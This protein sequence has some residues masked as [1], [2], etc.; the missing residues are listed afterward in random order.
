MTSPKWKNFEE[1]VVAIQRA[2]SPSDALITPNDRLPELATGRLREVDASIRYQVGGI[3][4]LITVECRDRATLEGSLWTEQLA[5]KQHDQGVNLTVAVSSS[6]FYG[7][8]IEKAQRHG[9][10]L[11][12]IDEV[13]LADIRS[14]CLLTGVNVVQVS[15]ALEGVKISSGSSCLVADD[16]SM[17]PVVPG[18]RSID[19]PRFYLV[20]PQQT[21]SARD[22]VRMLE[23][24]DGLPLPT[25]ADLDAGHSRSLRV[26]FQPNLAY[27]RTEDGW[28]WLREVRLDLKTTQIVTKTPISRVVEASNLTDM[29]DATTLSHTL[30]SHLP[31]GTHMLIHRDVQSGRLTIMVRPISE[32]G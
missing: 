3:P 26:I 4:L 28:K 17:L 31:D 1:L 19:G 30:E 20:H 32:S 5:T 10:L 29:G 8:A 15:H 7:P 21:M 23:V 18:P 25:D 13:T 9:I 22:L 27:V 2:L 14:W 11:R 16:D 24:N 6:G 12:R